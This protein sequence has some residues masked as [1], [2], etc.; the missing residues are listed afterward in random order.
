MRKVYLDHASTT[1]P[2]AEAV[3]A[4]IPY[5]GENSATLLASTMSGRRLERR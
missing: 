3:E 1:L 5:L 2:L 4:M